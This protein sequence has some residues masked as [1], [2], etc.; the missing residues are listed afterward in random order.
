MEVGQTTGFRCIPF[1]CIPWNIP[2]SIPESGH[3]AGIIRHRNAKNGRPSC[4]ISFHR[5]PLDSAGMTGFWQE[6]GG[7]CKDLP[8][9]LGFHQLFCLRRKTAQRTMADG[10]NTG[11]PDIGVVCWSS[12]RACVKMAGP[13][14][15]FQRDTLLQSKHGK[16]GT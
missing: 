1:L 2:V 8:T 10:R 7:H 4:Q 15:G 13:V 3:S 12:T 16:A 11:K 6:L 5:I 14:E 9:S